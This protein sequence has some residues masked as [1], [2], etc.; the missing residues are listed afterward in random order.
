MTKI[1]LKSNSYQSFGDFFYIMDVL[2][3]L[4]FDK[5]IDTYLEDLST[6]LNELSSTPSINLPSPDT[7]LRGIK[8][9]SIPNTNYTKIKT[10][11]HIMNFIQ[12]I[13]LMN[14]C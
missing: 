1:Q 13:K 8:E 4:S 2:K 6:H 12:Q 3:R 14:S 5:V 11:P 9:L 7:V 10:K